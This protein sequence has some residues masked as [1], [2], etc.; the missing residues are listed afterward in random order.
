M[1]F[2]IVGGNDIGEDG[3]DNFR[4]WER[5]H[6]KRELL[7]P[8][9]GGSGLAELRPHERRWL[10]RFAEV[11]TQDFR[12]HFVKPL[13]WEWNLRHLT[14]LTFPITLPQVND[15]SQPSPPNQPQFS[16]SFPSSSTCFQTSSSCFLFWDSKQSFA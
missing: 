5:D 11:Q 15:G 13:P 16:P 14:D 9:D 4:R 3:S 12:D 7:A 8:P 6:A 1:T 2:S 10:K